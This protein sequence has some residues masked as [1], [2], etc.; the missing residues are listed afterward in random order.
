[1]KCP[2]T[3]STPDAGSA[4]AFDALKKDR[5]FAVADAATRAW[6]VALLERGEHAASETMRSGDVPARE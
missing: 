3:K 1:M 6:I 2:K 4:S 5:A